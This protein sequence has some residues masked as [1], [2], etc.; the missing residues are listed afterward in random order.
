M[1]TRRPYNFKRC[2]SLS[3]LTIPVY[4]L[5][6]HTR[7]HW[8][9]T[10]TAGRHGPYE[11]DRLAQNSSCIKQAR[12]NV[13]TNTKQAVKLATKSSKCTVRFCSHPSLSSIVQV[14]PGRKRI[15]GTQAF[16]KHQQQ[17]QRDSLLPIRTDTAV[18]TINI[19]WRAIHRMQGTASFQR[20]LL[21]RLKMDRISG[22]MASTGTKGCPFDFAH[23]PQATQIIYFGIALMHNKSGSHY[24]TC[25]NEWAVHLLTKTDKVTAIFR[26]KLNQLPKAVFACPDF[27]RQLQTDPETII[28]ARKITNSI[29]IKHTLTAL[30]TI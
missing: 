4:R 22:W 15:K 2:V 19:T 1:T 11:E 3:W 18:A 20:W 30:T 12:S 5:S 8:A 28:E 26:F 25:G 13:V 9:H 7:A 14:W 21:H 29:C 24:S 17:E 16:Y 6:E 23:R 10:R 27:L